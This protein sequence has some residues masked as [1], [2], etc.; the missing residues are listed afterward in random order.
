MAGLLHLT[1]DVSGLTIPRWI[2]SH[3]AAMLQLHA[4]ADASRRAVA[5]VVTKLASIK[6]LQPSTSRPTQMT[7]PR[8]EL[9]AALLATRLLA[10]AAKEYSISEEHC[11]AWSDSQI[12]LHLIRSSKPT[13]NS[14]VDNYVAHI[15]ELLP[16]H[17]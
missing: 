14:L 2:S 12:V 7:I 4:F 16:S 15:Q 6:S 11:H 3:L 1:V 13:N 10:T 8:L 9:R 5:A 17:I